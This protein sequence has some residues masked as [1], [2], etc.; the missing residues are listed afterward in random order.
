M[1]AMKRHRAE[2]RVSLKKSLCECMARTPCRSVSCS[3]MKAECVAQWR[4]TLTMRL[5]RVVRMGMS[6]QLNGQ[7]SMRSLAQDGILEAS[8]P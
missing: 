2:G 6:R 3:R 8:R 4:V 5:S 1:Q 7:S